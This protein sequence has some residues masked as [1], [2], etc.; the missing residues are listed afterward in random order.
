MKIEFSEA[1]LKKSFK[2]FKN[3]LAHL[4]VNELEEVREANFKDLYKSA[5]GQDPE[6]P[7]AFKDFKTRKGTE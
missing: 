4:W 6:Q 3:E 2:D 7:E 5:T 1:I